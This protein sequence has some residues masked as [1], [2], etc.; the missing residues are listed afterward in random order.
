M[1]NLS[2]NYPSVPKEMEIF[3]EFTSRL[4]ERDQFD[5]L[6]PPYDPLNEYAL[7]VLGSHLRFDPAAVAV[8]PVPSANSGLFTIAK[9]HRPLTA[10]VAI[11]PFTFPGWRMIASDA[12]FNLH[13]VEADG[14]GMLPEKL[15]ECLE[16]NDSKLIYLQPTLHNPTNAVMSL[17]RRMA[18]AEVVRS[19]PGTYIVEDDAYRFLHADP[20]PSFLELAPDVTMHV[21]SLS[22][23]FNPMLRSGYVV[24][25]ADLLKGASNFV[26]MTSSGT[27][28]L[29]NQ[30][31]VQVMAGGWLGKLAD[32]KREAATAGRLLMES[33]FRGKEYLSH[34][35]SF[36]YWVPCREPEKV[37]AFL[38]S[39]QIDVS[40]GKM[41]SLTADDQYIRV[42]LGGAYD[43]PEL[44]EALRMIAELT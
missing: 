10:G 26:K 33:Y 24:H 21:F 18:I 29:F 23:P 14:E 11:E 8:T 27:S 28:T 32:L 34:P 38:L 35:N 16:K 44:P 9:Y 37:T 5:L 42:A 40:N 31:S 17:E 1:L 25:P 4:N 41:F 22:K 7:S 3:R 43:A 15:A 2:L 30:F 6:H 36:H 19:F 20:P 13:V 12:G 39:R